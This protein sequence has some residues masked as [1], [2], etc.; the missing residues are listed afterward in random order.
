MSLQRGNFGIEFDER[1]GFPYR[2]LLWTAALIPLAAVAL[3]L[4]RGCAPEGEGTA[5]NNDPLT[6]AR[7]DAPE[8]RVHRERPSFL[9][10]LFR[11]RAETGAPAAAAGGGQ[12]DAGEARGAGWHAAGGA[13]QTP[14]AKAL[15]AEVRRL[16]EL[17]AAREADGDL[18]AARE[19]LRK[20][21]VRGDAQELRPFVE[22]KLGAVNVA[23]LFTDRPAAE[24]ARHR[25]APGD[26]VGKLA[27][28]Y[29]CTQEYLLKANG[30]DR[31]EALR[32]GREVWVL[33]RPVFELTVLKRD[34][35]AVLTL[36]GRFFKRYP[37]GVG[38]PG[39]SPNGEYVVR[40]RVWRPAYRAPGVGE[41][42]SGHPNNILGAAWLGLAAA[43]GTP[44]APGFGLH[45]T[46]N[47]SSL[48]R[49][50]EEGRLRFGNA[51]IEELFT[52]LP[53]GSR[54]NVAD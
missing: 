38:R 40:D 47:E 48:G 16:L 26:L 12:G 6:A 37:I 36:N 43:E 3:V 4:T 33:T 17:A 54:V 9:Q 20:A 7:F 19:A 13:R 53:S 51:D 44:V 11:R 34:S 49:P 41:V 24:K 23:L 32:V 30:I 14:G 42:P 28:R 31:P 50:S 25:I 22:R 18:A 1:P 15:P 8:V 5:E 21:L 45:G 29:G 46:A 10:H 27:R 2:R 52:L 35:S 39:E